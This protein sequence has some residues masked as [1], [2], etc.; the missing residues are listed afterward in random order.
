MIDNIFK[1]TNVMK[2]TIAVLECSYRIPQVTFKWKKLKQPF[3][4]LRAA[5]FWPTFD[6]QIDITLPKF[7]EN[8]HNYIF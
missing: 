3:Y 2:L 7:W 6:I 1:A 8:V 4:F 5:E